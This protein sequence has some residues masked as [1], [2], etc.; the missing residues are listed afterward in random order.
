MSQNRKD[1]MNENSQPVVYDTPETIA[2]FRLDTII[3]YAAGRAKGMHLVDPR[4]ARSVQLARLRAEFGIS[5][6]RWEQAEA[7]L[8]SLRESWVKDGVPERFWVG[9]RKKTDH[10]AEGG[11]IQPS[12]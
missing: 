1:V 5:A 10:G 3:R 4:K 7:E 8:R 6:R 11:N 9:N 2:M 12:A